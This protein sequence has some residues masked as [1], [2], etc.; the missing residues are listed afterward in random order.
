MK[1]D[2]MPIWA[3][4]IGLV[5]VIVLFAQFRKQAE[6]DKKRLQPAEDRANEEQWMS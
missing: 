6:L 3:G 5:V 4:V 1:D 2:S